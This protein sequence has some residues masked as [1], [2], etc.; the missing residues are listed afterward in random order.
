MVIARRTSS[1]AGV[2]DEIARA[3]AASSGTVGVWARRL[4]GPTPLTYNA[5]EIFPTASVSK[6]LI[7]VSLYQL[8]E[9]NPAIFSCSTRMAS[10][11]S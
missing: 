7:L 10:P 2:K 6:V 8:G 4:D 1:A 11:I 3:A 9:R 5:D